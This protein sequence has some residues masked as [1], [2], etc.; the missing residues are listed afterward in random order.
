MQ[1]T[2][3]GPTPPEQICLPRW[4][5]GMNAAA[6]NPFGQ[7]LAPILSTAVVSDHQE[8]GNEWSGATLL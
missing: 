1:R 2:D 4:V 6:I 7:L 5:A 3:I 8:G